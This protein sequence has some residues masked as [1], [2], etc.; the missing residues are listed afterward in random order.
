L[1]EVDDHYK[2]YKKSI[3]TEFMR[4]QEA[5]MLPPTVEGEPDHDLLQSIID[6]LALEI[7]SRFD[8]SHGGFGR[9]P[10]FPQS[11]VLAL[12]ILEYHLQGHK[13]LLNIATKTL[14]K[15]AG[16]AIYDDAEGGFFR[17]STARDWSV[18]HYEKMCEDQ[19][20]LLVNYLE[21]YQVTKQEI[22]GTTARSI[23]RYAEA[24]LTDPSGGFYGSQDADEEYYQLGLEER[25]AREPPRIDKTLY[26][27]WNAEM[28]SAFLLAAA[29]LEQPAYRRIGLKTVNLLLDKNFSSEEGMHHAY[30]ERGEPL[31]SLLTDQTRMVRCLIDAYQASADRRSWTMQRNL[32]FSCLT[33]CR[34]N[35]EGFTT[36]QMTLARW[37]P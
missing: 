12:T 37:E 3:H 20:R 36:D 11:H 8:A 23:L 17:Y 30:P 4:L 16:G 15:M 33:S 18:P 29:V 21:A 25:K 35:R 27:N 31:R 32:Q 13:A 1:R 6:R 7:M 5:T 14:Q 9:A 10:K 28:I 24:T 22:F 19:A 34:A 2:K 26:T